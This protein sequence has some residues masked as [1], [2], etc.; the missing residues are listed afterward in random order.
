[1]LTA[2]F[3]MVNFELWPLR[4]YPS[5]MQQPLLGIVWTLIALVLGGIAFWAGTVY[6]QMD[7]M[8]FLVR[9]PVPFIFGTI[10]VLNMLQDSLFRKLSQPMKGVANVTA[11]ALIGT[12]LAQGYR[13]IAP[14]VTGLLAGGPPGYDLEIWLAS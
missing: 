12:L 3:F 5:V 1:A 4:N 2:M 14:N 8:V 7:A 6:L 9:V 13:Y 10:V 11:V